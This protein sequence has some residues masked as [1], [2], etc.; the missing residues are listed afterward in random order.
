MTLYF[1]ME[2]P[3]SFFNQLEKSKS[4]WVGWLWMELQKHV[5]WGTWLWMEHPHRLGGG[6]WTG[7]TR[8]EMEMVRH[9]W[10]WHIYMLR[11]T[12]ILCTHANTKNIE[13]CWETWIKIVQFQV[14]KFVLVS[15]FKWSER[16]A[17]DAET[18]WRI[19]VCPHGGKAG[20]CWAM[21]GNLMHLMLT[22]W[23]SII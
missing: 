21:L 8:G 22:V 23:E 10:H 11:E 1:V 7:H 2:H 16:S 20:Q 4:K 3:V 6:H 13:K 18:G 14:S 15:S 5:G 9:K 12:F 17:P 19:N